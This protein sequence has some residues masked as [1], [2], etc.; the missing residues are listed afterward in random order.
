MHF[1]PT[2]LWQ[3]QKV[4]NWSARVLTRSKK[5]DHLTPFLMFLATNSNKSWC[6]KP[7]FYSFLLLS[8]VLLLRV[9]PALLLCKLHHVLYVLLMLL[10]WL[11][12]DLTKNLLVVEPLPTELP[13]FRINY[14]CTF[15]RQAVLRLS[16]PGWIHIFSLYAMAS[17]NFTSWEIKS[18]FSSLTLFQ[19]YDL[20]F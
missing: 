19:L 10:T 2:Y 12:L 13:F 1:Y 9:S 16:N 8:M 6:Q 11:V 5:L 14:H 3:Q 7:P 15:R 20:S 18:L 17:P 4:S